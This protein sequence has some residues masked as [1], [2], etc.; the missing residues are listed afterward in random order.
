MAIDQNINPLCGSCGSSGGCSSRGQSVFSHL[1]EDSFARL[2]QEK[3]SRLYKKGQTIFIEGHPHHG[4]FCINSGKVKLVKT[5][6]DG[7]ET[8]LRIASPGDII[9]G[10]GLLK[11]DSYA[12]TATVIEDAVIC[13]ISADVVRELLQNDRTLALHMIQRWDEEMTRYQE[14]T[15]AMAH[16]SSKSKLAFM[17]LYLSK[18]FGTPSEVGVMLDVQLTRDE[19]ASLIGVAC[20]NVIR[21][22]AELKKELLIMEDKKRIFILDQKGLEAVA[23]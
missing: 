17:L 18:Q 7:S 20:E 19:F 4:L 6:A 14:I 10:I 5:T 15:H 21:C 12:T 13:L 2:N 8:L 16:K 1:D 9:G 11:S 3:Y 22:F 23:H